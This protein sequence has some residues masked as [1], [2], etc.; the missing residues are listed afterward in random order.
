MS[1]RLRRGIRRM[2]GSRRTRGSGSHQ[3]R[4]E[5]VEP[6]RELRHIVPRSL[7]VYQR[8]ISTLS[9]MEDSRGTID[10]EIVLI[11]KGDK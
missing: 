4:M 6:N 1:Q 10:G 2:R 8:G 5:F 3:R 7:P 9:D 11:P